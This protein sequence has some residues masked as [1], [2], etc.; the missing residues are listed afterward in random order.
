LIGEV[1]IARD[2][3]SA[4]SSSAPVKSQQ[5]T[6]LWWSITEGDIK[7]RNNTSRA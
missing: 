6:L 4:V 5:I 2:I 7:S 1:M 3:R